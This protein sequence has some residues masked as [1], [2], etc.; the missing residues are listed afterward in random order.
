MESAAEPEPLDVVG[1]GNAPDATAEP[2]PLDV[3]GIGNAPDATAEPEPLDVV[4]IGNAMVDVLLR[5]DDAVVDGLGIVKGAM[6]LVDTRRATE[7]AAMVELLGGADEMTPGGS[8]ANT[9]LGI[10]ALGARAGYMGRVCADGLGDLFVAD[11]SAHG[12]TQAT[13]RAPR[14]DPT[15]R[16]TVVITPDGERTMSTY[17]GASAGFAPADVDWDMVGRARTVLLEGY[18]WDPTA[19]RAALREVAEHCAAPGND[20]QVAL[21]LSDSFCVDRHRREFIDMVDRCTNI[22]FAN[23]AELKAL[24]QTDDLDEALAAVQGQV[25]IASV[26]LSAAGAVLVTPD[27][28]VQVP[29]EPVDNVVDRTGA[30]DLYAA[31]VL[32]GLAQG[33]DLERC[34][35][36]GSV[37]AAEVISHVGTRP[38]VPLDELAAGVI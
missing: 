16:C 26:T 31:G 8:V 5:A 15:G 25:D 34:G 10:A 14:D 4:G 38:L 12:V 20:C 36:L 19:A 23:A 33:F 35:R 7:L 21:S 17:L 22:L 24:Y 9:M 37:A 2:E 28:I 30:G 6:T 27:E 3:V 1:I 13:A 32:Y 18:L 29:V 11:M